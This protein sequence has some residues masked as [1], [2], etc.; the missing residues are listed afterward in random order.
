MNGVPVPTLRRYEFSKRP[1][2]IN[3]DEIIQELAQ[4]PVQQDLTG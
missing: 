4:V 2:L 1:E 3:M